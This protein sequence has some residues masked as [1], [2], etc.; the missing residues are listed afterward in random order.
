MHGRVTPEELRRRIDD[1][2]MSG[3]QW[4]AVASASCLAAVDGYDVLCIT[5]AA[6][7]LRQA[8]GIDMASLGLI[9]SSG[10]AGMA[11]GSLLLA[12]L[13]DIYGRRPLLLAGLAIAALAMLVSAFAASPL[14]LAGCRVLS[15]VGIGTV[16]AVMTS[17]S[18]EL[19]NARRRALVFAMI[20]MGFPVG[21]MIAGL[22][23]AVLLPAYGW[24]AI[25]LVGFALTTLLIPVIA[26]FVPEPLAYLV[27]RR[28]TD[29]IERVNDLLRRF[30]H[31]PVDD[32]TLPPVKKR[33]YRL[34]FAAGQIRSTLWIASFQ[35]LLVFTFQFVLS[36]LPQMIASA[37]FTPATA[38]AA[39]S[40]ASASGI[41]GGLAFGAI[42]HLGNV[43]RLTV[44]STLCL[45]VACAALGLIPPSL[46]LLAGAAAI[47]GIFLYA[48]Q[49]G[50]YTVLPTCFTAPARATG[51]GFVL[52]M[53]RIGSALSPLIAGLLFS[54]GLDRI[55]I[56]ACFGASAIAAAIILMRPPLPS[57]EAAELVPR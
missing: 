37:G 52:G 47:S 26:L 11:G 50:F 8:W 42:A 33:S 22:S 45:G 32:V 18:A 53:S 13:A 34:V 31:E 38:S 27:S 10:L 25:F 43:R 35:L 16:V 46:P 36:W 24:R 30:G 49:T 54:A 2:P 56:A 12:P 9:L 14:E 29:R 28:S 5:F 44:I 51:I 48:A 21:G 20:T 17:I 57:V 1:A 6:P 15:G 39:A 3:A 4:A 40:I 41:V 7:A 55:R 19:T 23:S